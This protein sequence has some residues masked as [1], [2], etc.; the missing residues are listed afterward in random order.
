MEESRQEQDGGY[1][2]V[3]WES[4]VLNCSFVYIRKK[5]F[6]F[7]EKWEKCWTKGEIR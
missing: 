6:L 4:C 2:T 7:Y 3:K 5:D 1:K